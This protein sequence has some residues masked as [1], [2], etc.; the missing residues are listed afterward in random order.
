MSTF[1]EALDKEFGK[2][3]WKMAKK[4]RKKQSE[5]KADTEYSCGCYCKNDGDWNLC[6]EHQVMILESVEPLEKSVSESAQK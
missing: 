1:D 5:P 4:L 3:F 6:P 2:G